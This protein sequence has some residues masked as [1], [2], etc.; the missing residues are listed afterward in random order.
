M[1]INLVPLRIALSSACAALTLGTMQASAAAP[2]TV[3]QVSG[4]EWRYEIDASSISQSLN[5]WAASGGNIETPLGTARL[6]QLSAEIDDNELK[7]RGVANAGW[8]SVPVDA[9]ATAS[10]QSGSVQV[11]VVDAHING[12]DVP[13]AARGQLEQQLQTQVAQ[14]VAGSGLAVRSVQLGDGKLAVTWVGP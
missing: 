2:P 14:S 5:A 11:H 6:Q 1:A 9:A 10:V 8:Y 7:V 12:M 3:N 13:D 4:R